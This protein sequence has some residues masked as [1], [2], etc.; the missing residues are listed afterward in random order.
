MKLYRRILNKQTNVLFLKNGVLKGKGG[1]A[2]K[3]KLKYVNNSSM[4]QNLE[5]VEKLGKEMEQ[6]KTA[7]ELKT[8]D[9]LTPDSEQ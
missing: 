9:E 6:A 1:K 4:A 5:E 3:K 8:V 7:T 2:K